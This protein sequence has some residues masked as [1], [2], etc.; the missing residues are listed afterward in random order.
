MLQLSV[1][2]G[3]VA[4]P[5]HLPPGPRQP[6]HQVVHGDVAG[7]GDQHLVSARHG[8]SDDLHH[9]GGLAGAGRPVHDPQLALLQA[10]LHCRPLGRVKILILE[11]ELSLMIQQLGV[12]AL[13]RN[14]WGRDAEENVNYG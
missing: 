1:D 4:E 13:M 5:H 10:E 8:R 6:L 7:R 14:T 9:G 12:E 2:A 3:G 11:D